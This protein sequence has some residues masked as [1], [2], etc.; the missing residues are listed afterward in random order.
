MLPWVVLVSCLVLLLALVDWRQGVLGLLVVVVLQDVFRKLTPSAPSYFILWTGA[1]FALIF[2]VAYAQGAVRGL[3]PLYLHDSGLR[4]AW[5]LFFLM[6]LLQGAHTLERLGNPMVATLG[7]IFY[8]A[9]VAALLVGIAYARS[10]R[11][12][13]RFV[14][15]YVLIM[16][17]T[18]LTVYLSPEYA[19][20]WPVLRDVGSFTGAAL[21][22]SGDRGP[23]LSHPGLLRVGELAAWHAATAIAFISVLVIRR[24]SLLLR[25]L[26]GLAIIALL[27]AI[28]L[29][30][31]RKMLMT[32][33]IFFTLQWTLLIVL[34]QGLNRLTVTVLVMILAGSLAFAL[35]GQDKP[36]ADRRNSA[37]VQRGLSVFES[38]DERLDRSIDLL[39]AAW[40]R[41]G[42]LGIGAGMAGQGARYA[43]GTDAEDEDED[44]DEE[45]ARAGRIQGAAEAGVGMIVVELGGAGAAIVLWLLYRLATRLWFGVGLLGDS[46]LVYAASFSALLIANMAT[47]GA[48]NQLYGDHAVLILL[49]LV[50]GMLFASVNAGI[51]LKRRQT[52]LQQKA[53]GSG[54]PSGPANRLR[55]GVR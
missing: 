31:R 40:Y 51:K 47:F 54:R 46:L 48:A 16:V 39:N 6:V 35:L 22:I 36:Q 4:R 25:I 5:W 9:P 55:P 52:Q 30:G 26:A 29:T 1:L 32:L 45:D 2:L 8:F 43:G 17:P 41:A 27:G 53:L 28:I 21:V 23:L 38:A 14:I 13:E 12:I 50:A 15:T 11:Q 20:D 19:K 49:G 24:P 7:L 3:R 18:A 34:R 37:Y 42:V 33:T 44:E 10:E